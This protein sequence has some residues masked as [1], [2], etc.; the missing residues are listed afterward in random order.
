MDLKIDETIDKSAYYKKLSEDNIINITGEGGSGKSMIAN[1]FRNN[2]NYVVVDYDLIA[3]SPT[4]GTVE[5][6]LRQVLLNK[7]GEKLFAGIND[8]GLDKV[9]ENFTTMYMEI[10]NYLLY[11]YPNKTI[12]LDGSQLRFITDVRMIKGDFFA[13]RAS[14]QTCVS[15]SVKRFIQNN[16]QASSD[17]VQEYIHKRLKILRQ[18]NPLMNVLLVQVSMLPEVENKKNC[19][20]E[21]NLKP[22]FDETIFNILDRISNNDDFKNPISWKKLLLSG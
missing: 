15:Q 6:E 11:K 22:I 20:F 4:V 12:V 19:L 5:Y 7:Y 16:P 18:L 1:K 10:I 21:Q 9:K 8:I 17:Q 14:L 13:L 2:D 3:L